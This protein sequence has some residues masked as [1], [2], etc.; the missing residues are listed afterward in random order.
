MN[1]FSYYNKER[2]FKFL[3]LSL[4]YFFLVLNLFPIFW[5][6]F[7]SF[8]NNTDILSGNVD[9]SR[10]RNDIYHLQT[11]GD[12]LTLFSRDGAITEYSFLTAALTNKV[13]IKGENVNFTQDDKNYFLANSNKG[14]YKINKDTLKTENFA[15]NPIKDVDRDKFGNNVLANSSDFLYFSNELEGFNKVYVFNKNNLKLVKTIP[16]VMEKNDVIKS[17]LEKDSKLIIGTNQKLIVY[18]MYKMKMLKEISFPQDS[19]STSGVQ[20]IIKIEG[21]YLWLLVKQGLFKMDTNSLKAEYIDLGVGEIDNGIYKDGKFYLTNHE[22]LWVVD[23]LDISDKVHYANLV[24]ELKD[25]INMN[26]SSPY[27]MS[28]LTA[29]AIMDD[30]FVIG[31]SY[32]RVS[33]LKEGSFVPE[34][35]FQIPLGHRLIQTQNYI[36]MY[37]KVD[38]LRFVLNSAIV[39][40]VTMLVAMFLATMAAYALVRFNFPGNKTFSISILATQMIPQIMY[41]IPIF[42]VFSWV[43]SELNFPLVGTLRGLIFLYSAFFTPFTIWILRSFFAS[44]PVE[45]EEAAR[46]DGCNSFQVFYKI[47]FPLAIPGII[48]TGIYTFLTAWDELMFA[49]IMLSE[50]SS[51]TIPAGIRLFVGNFQ[52]RY[53]LMMAAATIATLPPL[54]LF[55]LLQKHIV[56]G[57]TAGAVKG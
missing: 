55:F 8:K 43:G 16:L 37:K 44:I 36:D 29:V 11:Q 6:V 9:F 41:L 50:S 47:V 3:V 56:K 4:M 35:S 24:K 46:I 34:S 10:A 32:G 17:I 33:I 1:L 13:S 7:S 19:Y 25:G 5:M 57:L 40:S 20:K 22:G 27:S 26:N 39:S 48:A 15:Q 49:W 51:Q 21:S 42:L 53:D 52:N 14:I 28:E 30:Y 23:A 18:D 45:L 54:V 12:K 2:F 38:F 31:S